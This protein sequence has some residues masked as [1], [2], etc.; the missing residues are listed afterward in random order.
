MPEPA[1]PALRWWI[2]QALV[3]RDTVQQLPSPN[4]FALRRWQMCQFWKWMFLPK[5]LQHHQPFFMPEY[6]LRFNLERM[7]GNVHGERLRLNQNK[8]PK[9]ND[10]LWFKPY[11]SICKRAWIWK[12]CK[13]ANLGYC[14]FGGIQPLV[15]KQLCGYEAWNQWIVV[16]GWKTAHQI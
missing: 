12:P 16:L 5:L 13:Y 1:L 11:R 7:R 8:L 3:L 6:G 14:A 2:L 15:S 10:Q 9:V 4:P